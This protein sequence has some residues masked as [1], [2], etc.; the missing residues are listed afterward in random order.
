MTSPPNIL[1]EFYDPPSKTR[2]WYYKSYIAIVFV[3][4]W[5]AAFLHWQKFIDI[6]PIN[7][8]IL[9]FI[10]MFILWLSSCY[11]L[12]KIRKGNLFF[13]MVI[14]ILVF[15]TSSFIWAMVMEWADLDDQVLPLRRELARLSCFSFGHSFLTLGSIEILYRFAKEKLV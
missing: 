2:F 10:G 9:P 13:F 12:F 11:V 6:I 15:L 1:D 7:Q 5:G 14:S 8:S 4:V 3:L